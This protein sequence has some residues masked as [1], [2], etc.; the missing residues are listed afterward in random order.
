MRI[1]NRFSFAVVVEFYVWQLPF[2]CRHWQG[3]MDREISETG[4]MEEGIELL[5]IA[6]SAWL[7]GIFFEAKELD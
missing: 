3:M 2:W 7:I 4:S 1:C 6:R 5:A